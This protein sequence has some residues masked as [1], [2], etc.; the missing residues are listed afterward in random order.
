MC[1]PPNA[2]KP[3]ISPTTSA[4]GSSGPAA[5]S[6]APDGAGAS[7]NAA[8]TSVTI[9]AILAIVTIVYSL[10]PRRIRGC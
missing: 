10:A 1:H 5:V 6:L 4:L 3:A 7:A 9:A 8:M 2:N